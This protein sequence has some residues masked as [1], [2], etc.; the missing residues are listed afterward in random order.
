MMETVRSWLTAVIAVSLLC[1]LADALMPSGAV[2]RVGRLACGLVLAAAILSP[3]VRLDVAESQR[4]L[5]DYFDSLRLREEELQNQV[6][7][8]MKIIIE[9]ECAAYIVDK[10][11][12]LGL[13]CT[14]RVTCQEGS[15]G[16][17][18]PVR[19]EVAG[20]PEGAARE[21]LAQAISEELGIPVSEQIYMEK[22]EVP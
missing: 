20:A 1:A 4:W 8:Q 2:R 12:Q 7:N 14:A 6:D 11:A 16:L 9:G 22:E 13:T 21:R 5:E 19:A 17:Y 3:L 10:A 15:D 18:L